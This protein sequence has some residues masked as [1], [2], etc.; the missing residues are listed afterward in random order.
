MSQWRTLARR[1]DLIEANVPQPEPEAE[2]LLDRLTP[3]QLERAAVFR[4]RLDMV[5]PERMLESLTPDETM[6]PAE[7]RRLLTGEDA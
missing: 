2:F 4:A 7:L 1:V 6:E 3:E 5:G